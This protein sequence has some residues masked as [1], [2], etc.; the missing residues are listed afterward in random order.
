MTAATTRAGLLACVERLRP[1]LEAGSAR[2]EAERR[3]SAEAWDAMAAGGLFAM[4]A[5]RKHGGL[6]LPITDAMP[7]WEAVAR[8][9]G[10]AAWNLVMT[11]SLAGFAAWLPDEGASEIFGAGPAAVAGALFPPGVAVRADGGWRITGRVPFAS[12]CHHATWLAMPAFELENGTPKL[13]P[14]TG[15]TT[16]LGVFFPRAEAR[17]D[18]TWYTLGMRGTGSHDIAVTDL[19]VPDRRTMVVGPLATPA[20][21]CD[22]PLYRMLPFTGILGEATVSVGIAEAAVHEVLAL[23]G[24][25]VP[26]YQT[27]PMREQQLVQY[28]VGKAKARVAAARDTLHRAAEEAYEEAS[29]RPRLSWDAKIRLQLA[30]CFAADACA[31][32]VRLVH[33]AAGSTA[34]RLEHRFERYFRDVHTLTQHT[35]KSSARYASAGR[36]LLGLEDDWGG[37][38]DLGD[39]GRADGA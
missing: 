4:I 8:I 15:Q 27:L 9:D 13:D 37:W 12:G 36:L 38:C 20:P 29:R 33:D 21:G 30:V 25:K 11:S 32:A 24:T 6:E 18:D 10:A 31:E 1:V 35:S 19:F 26:A 14:V 16:P 7:V 39:S 23:A 3:L 34:I 17:I 5:P 28:H 2:A 22:G